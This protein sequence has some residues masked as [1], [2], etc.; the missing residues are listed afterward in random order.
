MRK[1]TR[2]G[3]RSEHEDGRLLYASAG[4]VLLRLRERVALRV[5]S[6]VMLFLREQDLLM[7]G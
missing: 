2:D 7:T 6:Y 1:F 4:H 5:N 3:G